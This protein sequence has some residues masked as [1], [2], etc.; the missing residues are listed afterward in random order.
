MDLNRLWHN[1]DEF[2]ING[3]IVLLNVEL[4]DDSMPDFLVVYWEE[5]MDLSVVKK[6]AYMKDLKSEDITLKEYVG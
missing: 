6:W 3:E 1:N 4:Q 2:P 5:G